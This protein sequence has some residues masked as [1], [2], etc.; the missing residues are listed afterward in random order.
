MDNRRKIVVT[1]PA[2]LDKL[3]RAEAAHQGKTVSQYLRGL[4]NPRFEE[5]KIGRPYGIHTKKSKPNSVAHAESLSEAVDSLEKHG[6]CSSIEVSYAKILSI[7]AR[8]SS[9]P[10][11]DCKNENTSSW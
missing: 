2:E 1:L 4:M 5:M 8:K 11:L 7:K 9:I 3:V 6:G 10:A